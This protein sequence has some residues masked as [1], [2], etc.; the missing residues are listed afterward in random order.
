ML[1][2]EMFLNRY[3]WLIVLYHLLNSNQT[4]YIYRYSI[5]A[6]SVL[7]DNIRKARQRIIVATVLNTTV[8]STLEVILINS[9]YV[10]IIIYH[11]I[12]AL[13]LMFVLSFPKGLCEPNTCSINQWFSTL[14][15]VSRWI[16]PIEFWSYQM[17]SMF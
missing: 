17:C 11:A 13:L 1:V 7:L 9:V 4:S 6:V 8:Q 16:L 10:S 14:C 2:M 5:N 12:T 3:V 15:S